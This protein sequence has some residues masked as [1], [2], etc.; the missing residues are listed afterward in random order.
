MKLSKELEL[1]RCDRPDE[2]KMDEFRR[3]AEKLEAERDALA[4]QVEHIRAVFKQELF[5]AKGLAALEK[6]IDSTPQQCLAE[7]RAEAVKA[8]ADEIGV[9]SREYDD[10]G[11]VEV[12]KW[13]VQEH[14]AKIRQGGAV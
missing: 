11:Y 10:Q 8:F 13:K 14:I 5:N 3:N 12:A 7:I 9:F 4:V 6:A 1:W 2:W